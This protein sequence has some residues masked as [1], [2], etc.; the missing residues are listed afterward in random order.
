[1]HLFTFGGTSL[2]VFYRLQI[3]ASFISKCLL[4]GYSIDNDHS[5]KHWCFLSML[6]PTAI[7]M[8]LGCDFMVSCCKILVNDGK[9]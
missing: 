7:N 5:S 6:S 4:N 2:W 9:D 1:V 3:S 8:Q